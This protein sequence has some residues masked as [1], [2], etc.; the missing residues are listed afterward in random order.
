MRIVP[1]RAYKY[2]IIDSIEDRSIPPG[3]ASASVG[4]LSLGDK[5]ELLRGRLLLGTEVTGVGRVSG[6]G[7]GKLAN[8]TSVIFSTYGKKVR[9][10]NNT[11]LD[12]V[13]VGTD[14]LGN[15]VV[16]A[17]DPYGEDISIAP[18]TN[19][20]GSQVWINSP[21]SA[22]LAKIVVA[23]PGDYKDNFDSTKNFKG[24]IRFLGNR[25]LLWRRGGTTKDETGLYGS[26][27][28]KDEV[29][30]FTQVSGEAVGIAGSTNYSGTLA[31][32]SGKR[33]AFGV[34]FTDGSETIS[35]NKDGTL[36]GSAGGTGTIN[37][38]T[39]AYN[40]TFFAAAVG[41]VTV[42]YYYEDSTAA[43]IADFT[44]STPRVATEGFV[45]RQDD[46]GGFFQWAALYNGVI[47][48]LHTLKTWA[49]SLS[50][51]DETASNPVY[52]DKVGIPNFRAQAETGQGI[53][54]IDDTDES[55]PRVRILTLDSN[56]AQV[57]PIPISNNLNLK[58]YRFDK[59][60]GIEWGD[61]IL[62]AC[63]EQDS[64]VNNRVLAYSRKWESW[65][66]LP[67]YVSCFAIK[68]GVL[69]AGD[70]LSNNVYELFSGL[71]DDGSI[72][73]NFW[74]GGNDNI[75]QEG[76]KKV[77][78]IVLEGAIGPSQGIRVYLSIDNGPFVEV[79]E[80]DATEEYPDGE[81]AIVG[82]GDYV[83]QS[84][85]VSVGA[86]TVGR[87]SV[88]GGSELTDDIEAYHFERKIRINQG[89]FEFAKIKYEAV[90]I[91]YASITRKDWWDVRHKSN[92]IPGKYR[93]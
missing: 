16:N 23:S 41:A 78:S 74:I 34:T 31:S 93:V 15:A 80:G 67:Y 84:N 11:I 19:L 33:T 6:L 40:I 92:K 39:G 68:D 88:A 73:E 53:Y 60:A 7:I 65:D 57:V 91:G 22:V 79:G 5:I 25:M 82:T 56:S 70:S 69:L 47:Y 36:T 51:D 35:D 63:R 18:Y 44:K 32:L 87:G 4:W 49:L 72:I 48:C 43:G 52:R 37:Y 76:M 85:R 38:T 24:L 1:R 71:D 54:Y 30:D 81:P 13:E 89:R 46:A 8:G 14:I 83:D 21:N 2:G 75:E 58:G 28:D 86:L 20:T 50:A 42:S 45:I 90:A 62:F 9:Y 77:P 66:V 17:T 26:K 10:Y 59:A 55:D 12:W 64:D 29:S 27:L 3:A 61:Y